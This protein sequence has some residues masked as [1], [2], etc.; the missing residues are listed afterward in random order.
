MTKIEMMKQQITWK[1]EDQ[2]NEMRQAKASLKSVVDASDFE[3]A[4]WAFHYATRFQ[5]AYEEAKRLQQEY[6]M[7]ILLEKGE[8]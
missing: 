7:L 5:K 1:I 2:A 3:I 8:E 4:S 6:E